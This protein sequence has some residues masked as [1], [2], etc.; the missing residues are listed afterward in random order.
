MLFHYTYI[1]NCYIHKIII[2]S[3][4]ALQYFEVNPSPFE[5]PKK[6]S[7]K[8]AKTKRRKISQF[9]N[10]VTDYEIVEA[11]YNIL[12]ASPDHFKYKWN[13]SKFYKYLSNDDDKV[14]W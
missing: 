2:F 6:D 11:C 10:Q 13:W 3:R 12:L 14:K 5:N 1:S 9:P 4:F 8:P 7:T